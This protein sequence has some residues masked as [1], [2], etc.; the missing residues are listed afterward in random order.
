[1]N[2]ESYWFLRV[3]LFTCAIPSPKRSV[4]TSNNFGKALASRINT[5]SPE[6]IAFGF[7]F[8]K[9][10]PPRDT[11]VTPR[12]YTST[13]SKIYTTWRATYNSHNRPN[14]GILATI[15]FGFFYSNRT[16]VRHF[17]FNRFASESCG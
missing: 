15:L 12:N 16:A 7:Y 14:V 3:N 9:I 8:K 2:H 17:A 11:F 13:L 10:P 6:F 4:S 5:H 1:M